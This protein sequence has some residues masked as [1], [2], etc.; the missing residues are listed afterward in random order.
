MNKTNKHKIIVEVIWWI[1]TFILAII[2]LLPIYISVPLFPF[3]YQNILLIICFVTF[4]RYIFLLPTTLIARKKWI[5]VFIIAVSAILFFVLTTALGDF[6]NFL[7]EEGLQT[8]VGHLHVQE[9]SRMMHYMK[10]EMVFFGVGSI[11]SG[12]VLPFRMI[13]SLWR[14]RN[15]GT[16]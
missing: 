7:D 8:L 15:R 4:T 2:V 3:Y 6:R 14:V 5:K 16:V 9:Q 1:F 13:I 10:S 12:I 11:L